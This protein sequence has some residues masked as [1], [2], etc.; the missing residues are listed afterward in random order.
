MAPDY[1]RRQYKRY[2]LACPV[3]LLTGKNHVIGR[4]KTLNISD[5]GALIPMSD[6]HLPACG[7]KLDV[8]ISVPRSTANSF[9]LEGFSS[10]AYVVRHEEDNGTDC[11]AVRFQPAVN[12]AIE[13]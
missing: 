5:G 11:I 1:D 13:V 12:F 9:M 8:R 10:H 4:G 7:S 2:E 6:D 3:V